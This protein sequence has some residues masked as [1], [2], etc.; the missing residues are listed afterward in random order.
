MNPAQIPQQAAQWFLL[1]VPGS[2]QARQQAHLLDGHWHALFEAT[3][4]RALAQQGPVLIDLERHPALAV[5]CRSQ[6]LAW[7]GLFLGS[8]ASLPTLLGHL[9]RM[10]TVTIGLHFKGL[11][12]YYN[13]QTAS[14][15]FDACD[16][17]ELSRWLGPVELLFWHGGTWAD[18]A[19]GSLGWQQLT[20]PALPGHRLRIEHSLNS[21]QQGKLQECLLERHA[22]QWSLDTELEYEVIWGHLQEG[23]R[24]GF[25]EHG[26]LD[27]WLRLRLR[28]P[29]ASVPEGPAGSASERL[30]R[31]RQAWEGRSG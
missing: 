16:A 29:Y 20:N 10:L 17:T 21:R 7:P 5:L 9:R 12:S 18:K 31:L 8:N 11:L 19:V 2:P 6:P 25:C 28:Y 23:L 14:Y 13:P 15:F 26:L 30:A 27:D 22:Y 24:H 3:D 1:D 4:L